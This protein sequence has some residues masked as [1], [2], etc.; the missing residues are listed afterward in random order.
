MA[1]ENEVGQEAHGEGV[2]GCDEVREEEGGTLR[3]GEGRETIRI[4]PGI[5]K[6]WLG[7]DLGQV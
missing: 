1:V 4:C 2:G 3:P 6:G 7:R 5:S